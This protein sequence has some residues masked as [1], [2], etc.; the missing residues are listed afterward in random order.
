MAP[1]AGEEEQE[2]EEEQVKE[3]EDEQE[4]E[5]GGWPEKSNPMLSLQTKT[6]YLHPDWLRRRYQAGGTRC[7]L[8]LWKLQFFCEAELL[9][10]T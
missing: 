4:E 9:A 6:I 10:A 5:V 7:N 1:S 8:Q 3:E 2:E